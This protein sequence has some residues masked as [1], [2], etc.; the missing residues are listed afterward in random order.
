MA[1]TPKD[2]EGSI[3]DLRK[4]AAQGSALIAQNLALFPEA[5][6]GLVTLP[7]GGVTL[8]QGDDEP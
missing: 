8:F 1:K 6:G 5:K 4:R 7:G 3:E 2:G